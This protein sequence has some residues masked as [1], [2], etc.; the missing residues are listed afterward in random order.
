[1]KLGDVPAED[2]DAA[3]PPRAL[4]SSR[5]NQDSSGLQRACFALGFLACARIILE[6][7]SFS[8]T[9]TND[10]A[11]WTCSFGGFQQPQLRT[12]LG[13]N[14][15]QQSTNFSLFC[16][17]CKYQKRTLQTTLSV[18]ARPPEIVTVI[19]S[20]SVFYSRDVHNSAAMTTKTVD[21]AMA[22]VFPR[23]IL[24]VRSLRHVGPFD[25]TP[26]L[27]GGSGRQ[28]VIFLHFDTKNDTQTLAFDDAA[29]GGGYGRDATQCTPPARPNW[30]PIRTVTA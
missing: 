21:A 11:V 22:T 1:M 27:S 23:F 15:F 16:L 4:K 19:S 7:I 24:A 3:F 28:T 25:F 17:S 2:R 18:E 30:R 29:T 5:T 9:S 14:P 10:A 13:I 8:I 26:Q 12:E 6:L 20:L